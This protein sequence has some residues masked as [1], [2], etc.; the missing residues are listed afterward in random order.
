M[1]RSMNMMMTAGTLFVLLGIAGL[2]MPV[3]TTQ[4]TTEVAKIG[5]LRLQAQ[6]DTSHAISP[7]VAG[8][9]LIIGIVLLGGGLYR[10][11]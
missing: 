3:F 11:R 6:E 8:G 5:A 10:R 2:T 4:E 9:A 1:D 7:L